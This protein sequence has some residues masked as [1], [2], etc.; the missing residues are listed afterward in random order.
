MSLRKVTSIYHSFYEPIADL[1]TVRPIPSPLVDMIDPFL[2]LNHHGPQ[3]YKPNN[4]GL[5]FGPHPHRGFQTVTFI[6]EG[7][8]AHRD[9]AGHESVINA[10]GVQWMSAGRGLVHEEI[11][12]EKFKKLGGPL[13]ILQLWIN[14][15]ARLKMS[16]PYYVGL[17]AEE[18]PIIYKENKNVEIQMI[19]GEWEG[20]KGPFSPSTDIFIQTIK[21][22]RQAKY[23]IEISEDKN[24]FFYVV[25]GT[26]QVNGACVEKTNLVEFGN[27]GH[28]LDMHGISDES[29]V[30]LC[31]SKP[32]NE[33]VVSQGPFVMNTETE[34]RQ[35]IQDFQTGRLK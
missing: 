20:V 8:I 10:G 14:L 25:Q 15:P 2:F 29:L 18:I 17:Q 33:P 3:N 11:S 19:S 31:T 9:S 30:L 12:S 32:N 27:Q 34:I 4:R 7:D 22:K 24:I 23:T 35:A 5:P 28:V 21:L 26:V 16:E 6:I 13:E 1:E